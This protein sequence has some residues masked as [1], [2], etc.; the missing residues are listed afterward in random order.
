MSGIREGEQVPQTQGY[1]G[2]STT[3]PLS[4]IP[5]VMNEAMSW[6]G[7]GGTDSEKPLRYS[8]LPLLGGL[9]TEPAF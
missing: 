7:I 1:V 8:G 3:S 5:F 9:K 4:K 6:V 2:K